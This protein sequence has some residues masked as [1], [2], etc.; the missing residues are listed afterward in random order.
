[1]VPTCLNSFSFV[2]YRSKFVILNIVCPQINY[3]S[4]QKVDNVDS[5]SCSNIHGISSCL[6]IGLQ[7]ESI[8]LFLLLP[9]LV[10]S[11][12]AEFLF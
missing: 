6:V 5:P 12:I 8:I 3:S 9:C 7:S 10:L 1:M 11:L 2:V 4:S